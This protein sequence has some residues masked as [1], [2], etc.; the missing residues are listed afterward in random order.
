MSSFASSA[1]ASGGDWGDW[2]LPSTSGV[3]SGAAFSTGS[4]KCSNTAS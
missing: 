4:G 3:A 2:S 1:L